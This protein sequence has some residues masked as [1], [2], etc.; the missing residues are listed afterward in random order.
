MQTALKYHITMVVNRPALR[1]VNLIILA[2]LKLI[3]RAR[4][5]PVLKSQFEI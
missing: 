4:T 2:H 1:S 3:V 5:A